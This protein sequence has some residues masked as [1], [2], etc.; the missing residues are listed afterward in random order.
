MSI[1]PTYK[2]KRD[3]SI[4]ILNNPHHPHLLAYGNL[5]RRLEKMR[6]AQRCRYDSGGNWCRY[7]FETK[8]GNKSVQINDRVTF[9]VEDDIKYSVNISFYQF[10]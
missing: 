6:K 8:N 7:T 3:T 4:V 5:H 1:Q 10:N 2:H 9:T